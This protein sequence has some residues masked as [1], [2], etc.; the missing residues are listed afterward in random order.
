MDL[1]TQKR[2][3][4]PSRG[5]I[6]RF[7]IDYTQADVELAQTAFKLPGVLPRSF[8]FASRPPLLALSLDPEVT[9]EIKETVL[10]F[11]RGIPHVAAVMPPD[12][13]PGWPA[14]DEVN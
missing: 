7:T 12:E 14:P 3:F 11:L 2:G 8:L 6:V 1:G 13:I 5:F 9:P 4:D 10:R